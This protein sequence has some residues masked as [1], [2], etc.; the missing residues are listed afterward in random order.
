MNIFQERGRGQQQRE[1]R[2]FGQWG[3]EVKWM[4]S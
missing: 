1:D 2:G 3:R 4:F